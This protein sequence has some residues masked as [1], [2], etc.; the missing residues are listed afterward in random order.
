MP[1]KDELWDECVILGLVKDTSTV[2]K[3][4]KKDA[5]QKLLDDHKEKDN[6]LQEPEFIDDEEEEEEDIEEDE[7]KEEDIPTP[8]SNT[9]KTPKNLCKDCQNKNCK[10]TMD[11]MGSSSYNCTNYIPPKE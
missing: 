10:A 4:T 8:P 5:L 11:S 2:K 6:G 1:T 3:N 7:E 9:P